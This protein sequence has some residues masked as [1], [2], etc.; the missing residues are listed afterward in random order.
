MYRRSTQGGYVYEY[1]AMQA[2]FGMVEPMVWDSGG[3][4]QDK[5]H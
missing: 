5:I 2:I 3:S 4:S 1:C